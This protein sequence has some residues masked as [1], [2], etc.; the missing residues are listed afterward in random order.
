MG[1]HFGHL[2]ICQNRKRIV[3]ILHYNKNIYILIIVSND[4]V[5][6]IDFDHFDLDHFDTFYQMSFSTSNHNRSCPH[7]QAWQA[8]Y[9]SFPTSGNSTTFVEFMLKC[10]LD[11]MENYE[12]DENEI[13]NKVQDKVQD[14]VQGKFPEVSQSAWDVLAII[15]QNPKA[16]VTDICAKKGLK[17][18]QVY[19]HISVLKSLGIIVRVGSNKTGYWKVTIDNL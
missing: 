13:P 4:R 15:Q 6:E 17:E 10:L 3:K 1:G 11:A 12:D 8:V 2:V 14:K 9:L 19:K 18:R 16:T 7:L 5:S